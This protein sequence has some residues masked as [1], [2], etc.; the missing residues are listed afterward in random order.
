MSRGT[1]KSIYAPREESDPELCGYE[2]TTKTEE[3]K[4]VLEMGEALFKDDSLL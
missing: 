2:I 4:Y 1:G 3:Y